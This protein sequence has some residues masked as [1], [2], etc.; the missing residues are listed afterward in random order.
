MVLCH[1]GEISPATCTVVSIEYSASFAT[2]QRMAADDQALIEDIR[3][4]LEKHQQ[5]DE[6]ERLPI[7][8]SCSARLKDYALRK[9]AIYS[10]SGYDATIRAYQLLG[11]RIDG[12]Q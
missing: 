12:A 9:A 5:T 11:R 7:Q 2:M 8:G 6:S 10:H 1:L 3:A 4:R